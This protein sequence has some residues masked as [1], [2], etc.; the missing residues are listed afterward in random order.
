MDD[1]TA[2]LLDAG[3]LTLGRGRRT[4]PVQ[5]IY[6]RDL[7]VADLVEAGT[8]EAGIKPIPIRELRQSHHMLARTLAQGIS[9]EEVSI[10]TGYSVSR[11]SIL[12]SDPQFAE[13]LQYYIDMEEKEY[14]VA[15]ADMH[16]RLKGLGFDAIET[17]HAKLLDDPD[18]FDAKTLLAVVEATS[19][20]TGYGKTSTVK[21]DHE[22]SLSPE[23]L[24]RIKL[25]SGANARPLAEADRASLL[26]LAAERTAEVHTAGEEADWE[27]CEGS[28]V[29]EEGGGGTEEEILLEG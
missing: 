7:T 9:Q 14:A 6:S 20:R 8:Q 17:L 18:S 15:R 5:A 23:T 10:I 29:R 24:E 16:E 4:Q 27:P 22:H 13:L 3:V 21:H 2:A 1:A 12:K 28:D 26:R 19:D 25:A 11:I